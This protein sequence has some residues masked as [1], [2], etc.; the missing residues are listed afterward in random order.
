MISF[1]WLFEKFVLKKLPKL[2]PVSII[3]KSPDSDS[4]NITL[5]D[6]IIFERKGSLVFVVDLL[7]IAFSVGVGN[8][9]S[10]GGVVPVSC[11]AE[12]S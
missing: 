11:E 10:K 1:D 7:D 2:R 9:R 6:Q 8:P 3:S 12:N 4:G 5:V